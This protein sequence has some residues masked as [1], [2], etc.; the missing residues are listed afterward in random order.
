MTIGRCPNLESKV[1][2]PMHIYLFLSLRKGH[3]IE[4]SDDK[5]QCRVSASVANEDR[6]D[7]RRGG[8]RSIQSVCC[9]CMF[10]FCMDMDWMADL[11]R[12]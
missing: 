5:C 9:V 11:E 4:L 7:G 12:F 3:R 8:E 1:L 6:E 10:M 2:I